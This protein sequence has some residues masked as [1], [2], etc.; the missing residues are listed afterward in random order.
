ML[1]YFHSLGPG[2]LYASYDNNPNPGL[3]LRILRAVSYL[4]AHRTASDVN[5]N[6]AAHIPLDS[7]SR[8]H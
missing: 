6:L 4:P 8:E 2:I 1:I 3:L 5:V 7:S